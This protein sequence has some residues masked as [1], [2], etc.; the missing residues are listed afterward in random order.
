MEILSKDLEYNHP[1]ALTI[2]NMESLQVL[3]T[4]YTGAYKG[5]SDLFLKLFTKLY[6]FADKNKL[7]NQETKWFVV[8]HDYCDLTAEEKLRLSVCMS[9]HNNVANQGEFGCMELAGCR[10]AVGKFSLGADD[11]QSAWN[12]MISR[13]LPDSGY[14]LTT[15]FALN[16]IRTGTTSLPYKEGC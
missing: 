2:Q 14:L 6:C 13:W 4:R 15:D 8:Y 7:V 1:V 11:Y 12:Y 9:I 10:Y 16:V 3:Y 5:N